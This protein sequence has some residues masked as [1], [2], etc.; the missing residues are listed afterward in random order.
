M[1]VSF[2]QMNRKYSNSSS[3]ISQICNIVC[4][5][6]IMKLYVNRINMYISVWHTHTVSLNH[7]YIDNLRSCMRSYQREVRAGVV[8]LFFFCYFIFNKIDSLLFAWIRLLVCSFKS[9]LHVWFVWPKLVKNTILQIQIW[10][11]KFSSQYH[12]LNPT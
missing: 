5:K 2:I 4:F 12:L 7:N 8:D 3:A 9:H 6:C 10:T 11:T 1:H